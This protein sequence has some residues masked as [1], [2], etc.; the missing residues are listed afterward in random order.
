MT[1]HSHGHI[2]VELEILLHRVIH[3][4][5]I[6]WSSVQILSEI[7]LFVSAARPPGL[8]RTRR[9]MSTPIIA[10]KIPPLRDCAVNVD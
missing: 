5:S 3:L 4:K 2:D 7:V 10:V 9:K 1:R 6:I 8:T